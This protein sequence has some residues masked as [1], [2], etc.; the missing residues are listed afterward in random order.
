MRNKTAIVILIGVMF[1]VL[2]CG[3]GHAV[4]DIFST[5]P[6]GQ[7]SDSLKDV[8]NRVMMT[9][10]D[11]IYSV[12]KDFDNL[13]DF[14]PQALSTNQYG[15]YAIEYEHEI[16]EGMRKGEFLKFGVTMVRPKDVIFNE[17]G[18]RAFNFTFPLLNVKF[19]GYQ[20]SNRK[21]LRFNIQEIVQANGDPLL[22]EQQKYLPLKLSLGT[23]KEIY[24]VGEN[25]EVMVALENISLKN[26]WVRNLDEQNLYFLYGD[27]QWGAVAA[28]D[29]KERKRERLM[30][31][32]GK[33]VSRRFV[34]SSSTIPREFEIYCSYAVTFQGVKPY[35]VI[36]VKVIE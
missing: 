23:D 9:I 3:N 7:V 4:E 26:L 1:S 11:H 19:A 12:K 34:G 25:I 18:R 27:A 8:C 10:Y 2:P 13:V 5:V 16:S 30:L 20:Q 15:I 6:K 21:W 31:E 36:K 24:K 35:G 14:G 17:Y 22:G 28:L 33:K 32:P 29:K